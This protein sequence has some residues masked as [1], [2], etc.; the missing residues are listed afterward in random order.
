DRPRVARCKEE[1]RNFS[2]SLVRCAGRHGAVHRFVRLQLVIELRW[3]RVA[4]IHAASIV[5]SGL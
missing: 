5:N 1:G 4:Q 2:L 3:T